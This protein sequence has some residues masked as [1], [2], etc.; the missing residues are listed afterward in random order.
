M[1]LRASAAIKIWSMIRESYVSKAAVG[2]VHKA[3]V[4][5]IRISLWAFGDDLIAL[6]WDQASCRCTK[7]CLS[8]ADTSFQSR[9]VI[10]N[11][12]LRSKLWIW[13]NYIKLL[14]C[15][16]IWWSS[17]FN[18][19][20]IFIYAGFHISVLKLALSKLETD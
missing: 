9:Q 14:N 4:I 2:V 18:T 3:F 19:N 10:T 8:H 5:L 1:D 12:T 20:N 17:E 15:L 7:I 13:K 6:I 11:W 16:T